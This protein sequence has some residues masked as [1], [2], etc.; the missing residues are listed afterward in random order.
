MHF[1]LFLFLYELFWKGFETDQRRLKLLV[2]K[3]VCLSDVS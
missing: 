1:P 3:C 2:I